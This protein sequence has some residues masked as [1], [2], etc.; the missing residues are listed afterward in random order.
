MVFHI[1]I[2]SGG[3]V[4]YQL[5]P[6][7]AS[8]SYVHEIQPSLYDLVFK[9]ENIPPLGIKVYYV[10]AS[11]ASS[12]TLEVRPTKPKATDTDYVGTSVSIPIY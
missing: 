8:F 9:A 4:A 6:V 7:I 2:F 12:S 1:N 3:N 11:K 10:E 5:T